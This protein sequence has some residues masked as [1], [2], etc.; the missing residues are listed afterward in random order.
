MIKKILT[1][2]LQIRLLSGMHIGGSDSS[3]ILEV[4]ILRYLKIR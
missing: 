2:D 1:V 4:Q 3:L